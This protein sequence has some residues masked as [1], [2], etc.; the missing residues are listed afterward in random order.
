MESPHTEGVVERA[1]ALIKQVL[2]IPPGEDF[3]ETKSA[4]PP[5]RG[6][7]H[8]IRDVSDEDDDKPSRRFYEEH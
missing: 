2:G 3:D 7:S 8:E 1:F 5:S 6:A 4:S